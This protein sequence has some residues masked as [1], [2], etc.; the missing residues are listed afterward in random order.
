MDKEELLEY[1]NNQLTRYDNLIL[2]KEELKNNLDLA[3]AQ[4]QQSILDFESQKTQADTDIAGY[5]ANKLLVDQIIVIIE[6][7]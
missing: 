4:M 6:A 5:N 2:T 7:S 1:L 3:I